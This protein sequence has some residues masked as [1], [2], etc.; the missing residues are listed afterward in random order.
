M[1]KFRLPAALAAIVASV[2]IAAAPAA[3]TGA[4]SSAPGIT[5][6]P[7]ENS[8]DGL[9]TEDD[10]AAPRSDC[11]EGCSQSVRAVLRACRHEVQDDYLITVARCL[12]FSDEKEREE[13]LDLAKETRREARDLCREQFHERKEVCELM[14]E[15]P[16]DPEIDPD[17]FYSPKEAAQNPNPYFPLVPG[18]RWLYEAGDETIE[19][20]VTEETVEILGVECFVVKDVVKENGE[21]I[22]DTD[23]WYAVDRDQNVWYFGELTL[24]F[25][26]G[27]LQGIEGSW[28]AGVDYAKPGL[29]MLAEP[30]VDAVYRQEFLLGEVEDLGQVLTITGSAEV[31]A[32]SCDGD[33]V[34]TKDFTPVEPGNITNKYYAA[35]IGLILEVFPD[36]GEREELVEF[37]GGDERA[38]SRASLAHLTIDT[39]AYPNPFRSEA[40]IRFDLGRDAYV[41]AVVYDAG[42]RKVRSIAGA[43]HAAGSH[44]MRW[45]GTDSAGRMS[46]AGV[47]FVRV[48]AG[49]QALTQ[50]LIFAR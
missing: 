33:C 35:G 21:V 31:P 1:W 5:S 17:D 19:V 24:E 26:G 38:A 20:T 3:G 25:E 13:C 6:D 2:S 34:I 29:I 43:M 4:S 41:T 15:D 48:K 32:A 36:S 12:N 18:Y 22:E 49:D 46:A 42:G 8:D 37:D 30:E 50:K 9:G 47:Y 14:G 7:E 10:L 16:Y 44:S 28:E 27:V 40:T 23:D 11:H 39:Q 45:D